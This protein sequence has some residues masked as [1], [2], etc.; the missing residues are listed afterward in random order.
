MLHNISKKILLWTYFNNP[1]QTLHDYFLQNF[2]NIKLF[3]HK[4]VLHSK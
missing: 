2:L 4:I 3:L 1:W